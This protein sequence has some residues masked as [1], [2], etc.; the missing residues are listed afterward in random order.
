M[1][2]RIAF[3][4]AAGCRRRTARAM[5]RCWRRI[6]SASTIVPMLLDQPRLE[7]LQDPVRERRAATRCPAGACE[8][9]VEAR[10]RGVERRRPRRMAGLLLDRREQVRGRLLGLRS[11][12]RGPPAGPRG[13]CARPAAGPSETLSVASIIEIDSLTLRLMPS[14]RCAGH[15]DPAGAAAADADQVRGGEQ[16]QAFAQ[17]RAADAEL[18]RELLLGADPVPRLQALS[19]QVA[20]QLERDLVTR[21]RAGGREAG[22]RELGRGHPRSPG[23]ASIVRAG[24]S[25]RGDRTRPSRRVAQ[26]RGSRVDLRAGSST[27]VS[28]TI[29]AWSESPAR[30]RGPR[31]RPGP[32]APTIGSIVATLQRP[33]IRVGHDRGLAQPS[34]IRLVVHRARNTSPREGP[35]CCLLLAV[36]PRRASRRGTG[37]SVRALPRAAAAKRTMAA[38]YSSKTIP[39]LLREVGGHR[40]RRYFRGFRDVGES[41]SRETR[42]GRTARGRPA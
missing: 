33:Q 42:R 13:T 5:S 10:V 34:E 41:W 2:E 29:C 24:K 19:L 7:D 26:T 14:P 37:S 12:P 4:A 27:V 11:W 18:G 25:R 1:C 17:R 31:R 16:P 36:Q 15:E 8:R 38:S 23:R 9:L 6:S 21:V 39:S 28:P 30:C 20:A 32:R 3:S 40:A 35:C 22:L